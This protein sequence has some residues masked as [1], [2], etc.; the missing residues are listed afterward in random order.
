MPFPQY[1]LSMPLFQKHSFPF[2]AYSYMHKILINAHYGITNM[3]NGMHVMFSL[4]A[5]VLELHCFPLAIEVLLLEGVLVLLGAVAALQLVAAAVVV[6][7]VI[8]AALVV[9]MLAAVGLAATDS[10]LSN[11]LVVI[12]A[13]T[14]SVQ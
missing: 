3:R 10:W 6:I 11:P 4:P 13:L 5:S 9:V 1:A 7:E 14:A 12:V 8:A 2:D